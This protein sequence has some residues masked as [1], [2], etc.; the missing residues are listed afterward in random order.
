M[1]DS[2]FMKNSRSCSFLKLFK[3]A[4]GVKPVMLGQISQKVFFLSAPHAR[5]AFSII[6]ATHQN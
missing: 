4:E 3:T 1:Y 2:G 6:K 5:F